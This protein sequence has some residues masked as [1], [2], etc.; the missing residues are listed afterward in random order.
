[1]SPV[2]RT[3]THRVVIVAIGVLLPSVT[4]QQEGFSRVDVCY[5]PRGRRTSVL[6]AEENL[7]GKKLHAPGRRRRLDED[8]GHHNDS[9]HM[10][11]F[12]NRQ[13]MSSGWSC[14]MPKICQN[15]MWKFL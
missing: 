15:N 5:E 3:D 13:E 14:R 1:R 9:K 11:A 6:M 4:V 12:G 10:T 8:C 7:F 2:V